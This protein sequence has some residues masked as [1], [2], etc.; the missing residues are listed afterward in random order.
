M[1]RE[2]YSVCKNA[3]INAKYD[4]NQKFMNRNPNHIV[5]V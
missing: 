5:S 4:Y 3:N 2:I 1:S